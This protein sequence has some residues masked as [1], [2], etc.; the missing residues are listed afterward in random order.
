MKRTEGFK[1]R[2]Q[3][4]PADLR[5]KNLRKILTNL[6][7]RSCLK[8]F[9]ALQIKYKACAGWGRAFL[10]TMVY[11]TED[12]HNVGLTVQHSCY[13]GFRMNGSKINSCGTTES[14]AEQLNS[15][16]LFY[17]TRLRIA[18]KSKKWTVKLVPESVSLR[19]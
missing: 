10:S 17:S 15:P 9:I 3:Y 2:Q 18:I 16:S 4:I 1:D 12:A 6:C 5:Y 11:R 7:R 19:K 13:S 14:S 8:L